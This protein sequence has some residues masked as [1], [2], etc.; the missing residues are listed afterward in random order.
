MAF[1]LVIVITT[2]VCDGDQCTLMEKDPYITID[3]L[4]DFLK[5]S[6]V[7]PK[8]KIIEGEW[9]TPI[10]WRTQM[11][12]QVENNGRGRSRGTL[13]SSQHFEG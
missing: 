11:W 12:V 1:H 13:P 8:V 6:N 7:N 2:Y 5:D 4:P 10:P 3:A 9:C